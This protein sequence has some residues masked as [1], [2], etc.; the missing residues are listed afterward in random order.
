[1]KFVYDDGGRAAAGFKGK[2][3]DCVCRAIAIAT[4]KPYREVYSVMK[5]ALH[6][7][8]SAHRDRVAKRIPF[9]PTPRYGMP[10]AVYKPHL[11][12]IGWKWI[13]TMHIG[14]GCRI[15]L[16]ADEL[17]AGRLIVSVSRHL[18]AVIDGVIHDIY[19]CSRDGT[20]CVYG[21]FS[22]PSSIATAHSKE[23][24]QQWERDRTMR[25][26]PAII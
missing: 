24:N 4:N 21:Y 7:Y 17:P 5:N 16:R 23:R 15:H 20:R 13:P 11:L 14:S 1:M 12:A 2:A 3:G 9:Q 26:G 10:A 22:L 8:A 19:D 6:N 18:V 25:T